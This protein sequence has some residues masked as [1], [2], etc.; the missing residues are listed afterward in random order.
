V[1]TDDPSPSD[2]DRLRIG[3]LIF[4]GGEP[5]DIAKRYGLTVGEIDTAWDFC[6]KALSKHFAISSGESFRQLSDA[7]LAERRLDTLRLLLDW[8]QALLDQHRSRGFSNPTD[9]D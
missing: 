6:R 7:E 4:D 3:R 2:A 1:D 8:R 9:T 5:A